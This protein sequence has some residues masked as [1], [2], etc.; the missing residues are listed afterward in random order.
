MDADSRMER[1]SDLDSHSSRWS[2]DD[3]YDSDLEVCFVFHYKD[4][5]YIKKAQ[6]VYEF[7]SVVENK[8]LKGN[9]GDLHANLF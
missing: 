1:G 5:E 7:F 6:R 9:W 2:T 3:E 4:P 8:F